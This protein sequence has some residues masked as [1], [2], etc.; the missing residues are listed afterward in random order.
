M[1]LQRDFGLPF[2]HFL[3]LG[4]VAQV[5]MTS[6]ISPSPSFVMSYILTLNNISSSIS[7]YVMS[8]RDAITAS[9]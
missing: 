8:H 5:T 4:V 2:C 3:D 7:C 1:K 9:R 6:S